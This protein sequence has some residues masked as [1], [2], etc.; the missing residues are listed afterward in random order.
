MWRNQGSGGRWILGIIRSAGGA[1]GRVS[2]SWGMEEDEIIVSEELSPAGL[3][4][5]EDFGRHECSQ[6][7][8]IRKYL[9]R[10]MRSL[11]IMAPMRH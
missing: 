2:L 7:L 3:A 11:K 4:T 8:V 9:N 6:V 10:V 5:V 1:V